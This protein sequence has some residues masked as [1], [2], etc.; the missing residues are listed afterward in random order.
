MD[1]DQMKKTE[2]ERVKSL[3][4]DGSRTWLRER[5][6]A[7]KAEIDRQSPSTRAN[8]SGRFKVG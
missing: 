6:V 4:D 7:T 5:L 1:A 2:D 3:E 8:L